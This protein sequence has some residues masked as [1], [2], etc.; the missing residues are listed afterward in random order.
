MDVLLS[1]HAVHAAPLH[2]RAYPEGLDTSHV[3]RSSRVAQGTLRIVAGSTDWGVE[4]RGR[5]DETDW[6]VEGGVDAF[7]GARFSP[8]EPTRGKLGFFR[9]SRELRAGVRED[10]KVIQVQCDH[11]VPEL[12]GSKL[13]C[14]LPR[15]PPR[16]EELVWGRAFSREVPGIKFHNKDV[17]AGARFLRHLSPGGT[18]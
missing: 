5:N 2:W 9:L 6:D 7:T 4:G 1:S 8:G 14:S 17:E 18:A 10:P 3:W 11:S 12:L 16:A 15:A 13:E